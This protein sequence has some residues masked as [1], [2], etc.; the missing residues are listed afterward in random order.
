MCIVVTIYHSCLIFL[1]CQTNLKE[2]KSFKN[3]FIRKCSNDILRE[4]VNLMPFI[5]RALEVVRYHVY[6]THAY[7]QYD[8]HLEDGHPCLRGCRARR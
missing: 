3:L 2:G 8:Q 1:S 5:L 6:L 7:A 4:R